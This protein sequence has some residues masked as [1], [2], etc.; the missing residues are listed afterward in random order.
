NEIGVLNAEPIVVYMPD[1]DKLGEY[2]KDFGNVLGTFEQNPDDGRDGEKGF[3]ESD[4]IVNSFRLYKNLEKDNDNQV[5]KTEF[6]KARLF[7]LMIGD[8]DRH[9]DQWLWA[10]YKKD[11]KTIYEPIPRD[12]DQAFSLYDGLLPFIVGQSITQIEGYSKDYPKIYDLSF[13]GRYIDRRFLPGVEKKVYDSLTAF[14][15]IKI[16]DDVI[17]KAVKKMPEEWYKLEGKHLEGMIKARRDNLKE[18]SDEFYDLINETVDIY[19][20][21]K[22]EYIEVNNLN[23]SRV[24]I[25]FYKKDKVTGEKKGEPFFVRSYSPDETNEIRM[26]L[27]GGNDV[28]IEKGVNNTGIDVMAITGKD[29]VKVFGKDIDVVKDIRPIT[30]EKE[31]YEPLA[32]D[33]GYDWRAGPVLNYNSDDGLILGGGPIL[34]KHSYGVA[35]YSYRMSLLGSY[36]FNAKSYSIKYTGEFYSIIKGV[37]IFLDAQKTE[38][39]ITRFF[40][41]GNETDLNQDLDN[42]D[43][44]KVGQEL[45]YVSPNFEIPLTKKISFT[46][47]PFYKYS[48]V[49]YNQN[50]LLGQNPSTYGI[51]E[52]KFAGAKSSLSFD[53][54]DNKAEPYKGLYAQLLGN[55]TPNVFKNNFGFSKAGIDLRGYVSTDSIKGFTFV[56]RA[57]AGKV[58]GNFPFYESMFL[59][60]ANSL[61]GFSRERFAGD[62]VVLAQTEI[63][64]RLFRI[65]FILPGM[66]GLSAFGGAGR[67]YLEGE[68]SKRWHS[69]YGGSAW[70]TYLNRAFNIGFTV[71]KSDEGFKYFFGTG[72][73]L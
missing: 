5:D 38:L 34:Y 52:I 43:F 57:A 70:I 47:S 48:D 61:K 25:K 62:G 55:Y 14:I 32:E 29:K 44:Y 23:D 11:G 42:N 35:P 68:S 21:R 1:D 7:D 6:L 9:S 69:A 46:I 71:A 4:K 72:L 65:N 12:R 63:R 40:G 50:T 45:F 58:W 8:W 53:S 3:A 15:Q 24:E 22:N 36:A 16:S 51:G 19:A 18:A 27:N 26:Y 64:A 37:R 49:S 13:N 20:S 67:V 54:R 2:K 33:R 30:D 39:G 10:G 31:R 17:M 56:G 28:V 73:F 60:G 66:F 59:G 41:E